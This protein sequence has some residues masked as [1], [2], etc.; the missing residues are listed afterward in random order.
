[1]TGTMTHNILLIRFQGG[2]FLL[3]QAGVS[4]DPYH[5]RHGPAEEGRMSP[6]YPPTHVYLYIYIYTNMESKIC[7]EASVAIME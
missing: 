5:R 2:K 4:K 7:S 3:I 6:T 1:M